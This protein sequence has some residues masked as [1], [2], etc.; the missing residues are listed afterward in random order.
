M[1]TTTTAA[2]TARRA[3]AEQDRQAALAM[4]P[5]Q[6]HAENARIARA[7]VTPPKTAET[8]HGIARGNDYGDLCMGTATTVCCGAFATFSDDDL[9]CRACYRNVG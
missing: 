2:R 5:A 7:E 4:T 1:A 6:V 9:V 8:V 3:R